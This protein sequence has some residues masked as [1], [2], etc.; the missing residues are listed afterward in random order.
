MNDAAHRKRGGEWPGVT[1]S[2]PPQALLSLL[3]ESQL[4]VMAA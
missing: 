3:R 4:L 1:E 2:Q